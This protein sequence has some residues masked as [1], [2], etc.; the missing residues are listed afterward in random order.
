MQSVVVQLHTAAAE[1]ALTQLGD[2]LPFAVSRALN[3]AA[4]S[5]RVAMAREVSRNLGLKVGT[6]RERIGLQEARP[7]RPSARLTASPKRIPLIEFSASGPEP[8]R[9]RGRVSARVG[10]VRKRYPGAFIT[11]MRSGHRGVFRRAGKS[12]SRAG[13]RR[14]SPALPIVELFG[15]SIARVFERLRSLGTARRIESLKKN[16]KSELKF[17]LKHRRKPAA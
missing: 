10:G 7:Q 4:T 11:R 17:E 13:L 1:Q 9:G 5:E 12:R 6:V 2:R 16:L 14:S 3:R 15:P 8:S